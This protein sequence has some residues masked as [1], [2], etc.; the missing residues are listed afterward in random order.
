MPPLRRRVR[1]QRPSCARRSAC[2]STPPA[3]PTARTP[4]RT[5]SRRTRRRRPRRRPPAVPP[6]PPSPSPPPPSPPNPCEVCVQPTLAAGAVCVFDPAMGV[7][8]TFRPSRARTRR[9]ARTA[10]R[11]ARCRCPRRRRRR[12]RNRRCRRCRTPTAST[13]CRRSFC[14]RRRPVRARPPART[15]VSGNLGGHTYWMPDLVIG[16]YERRRPCLDNTVLELIPVYLLPKQACGGPKGN[17]PALPVR[18]AR[19]GRG[20]VAANRC[21]GGLSPASVMNSPWYGWKGKYSALGN[22]TAEV[23][24]CYAAWCVHDIGFVGDGGTVRSAS[25][26]TTCTTPTPLP[27][28]GLGHEPLGRRRR[29][30]RLRVPGLPVLP[31]HVPLAATPSPPPPPASPPR[32]RRSNSPSHRRR[33]SHRCRHPCH[34]PRRRPRRL[35]PSHPTRPWASPSSPSMRPSSPSSFPQCCSASSCCSWSCWAAAA[36]RP[37]C[38]PAVDCASPGQNGDPIAARWQRGAAQAQNTGVHINE[39]VQLLALFRERCKEWVQVQTYTHTRTK[40]LLI[41]AWRFLGICRSTDL[42]LG[43]PVPWRTVGR[44]CVR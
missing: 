26:S 7:C 44:T 12:P 17:D 25:S 18:H 3:P 27:K 10:C 6:T 32:I 35:R 30:L 15:V 14:S 1:E 39:G 40:C 42:P 33:R 22:S 13:A 8:A 43:L 11:R 28:C 2:A 37:Q 23:Q 29:P 16:R 5:A 36:A 9:P 38:A 34:P 4:W 20:R 41:L 31:R 21:T 19:G 24:R